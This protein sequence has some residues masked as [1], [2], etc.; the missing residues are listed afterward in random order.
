VVWERYTV[1]LEGSIRVCLPFPKSRHAERCFNETAREAL[2]A[3]MMPGFLILVLRTTR[4][5]ASAL[6]DLASERP[7]EA[8]SFGMINSGSYIV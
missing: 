8:G 5:Q 2:Q 3:N 6:N 4:S 7:E 1:S